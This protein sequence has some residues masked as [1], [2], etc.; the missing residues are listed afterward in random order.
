[1]ASV[2]AVAVFTGVEAEFTGVEAVF[3]AGEGERA[4]TSF[5][6]TRDHALVAAVREGMPQRTISSSGSI[7]GA[8]VIVLIEICSSRSP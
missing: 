5:A 2:A 4:A 1:M 3:T 6:F 8:L 7:C